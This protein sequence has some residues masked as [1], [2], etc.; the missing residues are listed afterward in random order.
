MSSHEMIININ[1]VIYGDRVQ[2][3][4]R[5]TNDSTQ[6]VS[7]NFQLGLFGSQ[8]VIWKREITCL[9][10]HH[11]LSHMP[12]RPADTSHLIYNTKKLTKLLNTPKTV[13]YSAIS[14]QRDLRSEKR[15]NENARTNRGQ[16]LY[17]IH[18]KYASSTNDLLGHDNR[19]A[20]NIRL[21]TKLVRAPSSKT[22]IA[23][24]IAFMKSIHRQII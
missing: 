24:H 5:I 14:I 17:R 18:E 1:Y 9:S 20:F 10:S 3:K 7:D 23:R 2:W 16:I 19:G 22:Q 21:L 13:I 15:R 4:A 12:S 8:L 6:Y 11:I